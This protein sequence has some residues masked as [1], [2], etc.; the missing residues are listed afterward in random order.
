MF[1]LRV[2]RNGSVRVVFRWISLPSSSSSSSSSVTTR[3][4]RMFLYF[5][6][7]EWCVVEMIVISIR[8]S[9]GF[10]LASNT[11]DFDSCLKCRSMIVALYFYP[12]LLLSSDVYCSPE[13]DEGH[14]VRWYCSN[15]LSAVSFDCAVLKREIF[16]RSNRTRHESYVEWMFDSTDCT[17]QTTPSDHGWSFS[18]NNDWHCTLIV[19]QVFSFVIYYW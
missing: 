4:K 11:H 15:Y 8:M 13:N 10:F 5:N 1:V 19:K 9:E 14:V 7:G 2:D 18:V 6:G 16:I 17:W 3:R 12:C